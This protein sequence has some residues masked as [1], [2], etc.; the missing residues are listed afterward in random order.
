MD[1]PS[2]QAPSAYVP[3][4]TTLVKASPM[5][6]Q[7]LEDLIKRVPGAVEELAGSQRRAGVGTHTFV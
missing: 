2:L 6:S 1:F 3:I 5:E 7:S 4:S